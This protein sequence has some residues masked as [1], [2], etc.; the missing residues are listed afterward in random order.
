MDDPSLELAPGAQAPP[1]GVP[2]AAPDIGELERRFVDES[3]RSGWVAY[4]SFVE[5]LEAEVR[6]LLGVDHA[7]GVASGTA[8]LHLALLVAGVRPGDEVVVPALSFISPAF[9]IRYVGA[10]PVFVDAEPRYRQL[11][12]ERLAA[13]LED[14]CDVTA[15]GLIRRASGRRIGAIVPVDVLGHPADI[16]AVNALASKHGVPVVEDAAEALGASLRGRPAGALAGI[17]CLSFNGNKIVTAGSGGMVVSQDAAVAERVRY[18]ATQAKDDP[19]EY[20]HGAI[21]F[22]YRLSN[23]HAALGYG[24]LL[25]LEEFV[26]AKRRIAAAYTD[27]LRAVPGIELPAEAADAVCTFWL[28]TIHVHAKEYGLSSRELL[29]RLV[30][31]GIQARPLWQPLHRSPAFGDAFQ[32]ACPVADAL[33]ATGLSL[34]SSVTLTPADQARVIELIARGAA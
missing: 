4:G 9:A 8:A 26:A 10:H 31:A 22:N 23:V 14:E 13:L 24:Q 6:G 25:R 1:G 30:Q 20:V 2:L 34:P 16:D 3:L 19:L 7:V 21:G 12:P 33:H 28:Y 5:R 17:G 29:G 15:E 11:D 18:L 32:R 27:S